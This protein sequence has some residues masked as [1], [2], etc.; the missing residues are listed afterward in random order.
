MTPLYFQGINDTEF[1]RK[2]KDLARKFH[3]D[4]N[5]G[6]TTKFMKLKF[7]YEILKDEEKKVI[8]DVYGQTDF[9][10]DDRML[11]MIEM[12]FKKKEEREAQWKAY[13]SA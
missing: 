1:K 8:Y 4:K 12:T 5:N 13:K 10:Q 2:Y 3:P 7:A 6:D 9:S 11:Q